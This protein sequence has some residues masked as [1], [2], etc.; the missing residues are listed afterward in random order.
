[1]PWRPKGDQRVGDSM[2]TPPPTAAAMDTLAFEDIAPAVSEL[3]ATFDS[4]RTRP[5]PFRLAQLR[6][7][8]ALLVEGEGELVAA[9]EADLGR[10]RFETTIYDIMVTRREV[11]HLIGLV[12]LK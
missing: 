3:R 2:P 5:V 8:R 7:L 4:Q 10:P 9:V 12:H 6:A 1:M 11:E